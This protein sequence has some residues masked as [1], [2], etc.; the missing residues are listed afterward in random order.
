MD[1][2]RKNLSKEEI[3]GHVKRLKA[4]GLPG[5]C[6]IRTLCFQSNPWSQPPSCPQ[7]ACNEA[8]GEEMCS[9]RGPGAPSITSPLGVPPPCSFGTFLR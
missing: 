7:T 3:L 9:T 8:K 6:F 4:R 2:R 1:F 5:I